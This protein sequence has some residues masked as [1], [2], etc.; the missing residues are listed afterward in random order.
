[1]PTKKV[2]TDRKCTLCGKWCDVNIKSFTALHSI[3]IAECA[4]TPY[5]KPL[6]KLYFDGLLCSSCILDMVNNMKKDGWLV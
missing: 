2:V 5:S 6:S 1:M 3:K 4:K